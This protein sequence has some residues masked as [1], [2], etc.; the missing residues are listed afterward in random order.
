MSA[1]HTL[2]AQVMPDPSL[3]GPEANELPRIAPWYPVPTHPYGS[4]V[5]GEPIAAESVAIDA[6]YMALLQ[7]VA[8]DRHSSDDDSTLPTTAAPASPPMQSRDILSIFP[9]EDHAESSG[10]D[11][12]PVGRRYHWLSDGSVREELVDESA[13][14]NHG[15][16][17]GTKVRPGTGKVP[18]INDSPTNLDEAS[19]VGTLG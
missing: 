7:L 8:S 14:Q 10:F 18:V 11:P 16:S 12:R 4:D 6:Y 19:A 9:E 15:R 13:R 5:D 3:S 2:Q 1:E 17:T